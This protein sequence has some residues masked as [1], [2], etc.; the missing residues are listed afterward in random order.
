MQRSAS[1][2]DPSGAAVHGH[3]QDGHGRSGSMPL[4]EQGRGGGAGWRGGPE[5]VGGGRLHG[6][7]PPPVRASPPFSGPET[8]RSVTS[9][10]VSGYMICELEPHRQ[11]RLAA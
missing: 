2:A 11:D 3:Q 10:S 9:N 6:G 8:L 1:T 5:G 7:H 4:T